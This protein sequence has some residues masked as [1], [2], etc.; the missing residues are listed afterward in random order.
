MINKTLVLFIL[1][2]NFNIRLFE[3]DDCYHISNLYHLNE[4]EMIVKEDMNY[5][6]NSYYRNEK[7]NKG[8]YEYVRLGKGFYGHVIGIKLLNRRTNKTFSAALKIIQ[9]KNDDTISI[10]NEI[11]THKD[12]SQK[13]PYSTS[14]YLAC[15]KEFETS[16]VFILTEQLEYNLKNKDWGK[17]LSKLTQAQYVEIFLHMAQSLLNLHQMGYVHKDIHMNNWVT[18]P[19]FYSMPKLIDFGKS[20][21]FPMY[22]K[23]LAQETSGIK[24]SRFRAEFYKEINKLGIFFR[25]IIELYIGKPNIEDM[26]KD[27]RILHRKIID[28][29]AGLKKSNKDAGITLEETVVILEN[30]LIKL[31][32]DSL[33]LSNNQAKL[34]E[35]FNQNSSL[36]PERYIT[37][38]DCVNKH[39]KNK[40]QT[41][42]ETYIT[43]LFLLY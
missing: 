5:F 15:F 22:D 25:R 20:V 26:S 28:I 33:F 40:K 2:L 39:N 16:R 29:S 21:H 35:L 8:E 17:K 18:Q 41:E 19:G 1:L 23:R 10:K 24:E 32:K 11:E 4:F 42:Y 38:D 13:H 27:L 43:C 9:Y 37:F 14:R 7:I 30:L 31:D 6:I 3:L 36:D 12:F 34:Y